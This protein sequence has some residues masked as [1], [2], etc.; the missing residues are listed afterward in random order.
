M[1]AQLSNSPSNQPENLAEILKSLKASSELS[2]EDSIS[3]PPEAFTS[4]ALLEL[5]REKIFSKEWICVGREGELQASGDYFVTE[6]NL[7]PVIMTRDHN[8]QL[9]ALVNVC[10]H[11][12]ARIADGAG[13]TRVFTCPYHSWAYDLDGRLVNAPKMEDKQF[14]KS[15]C[16][17]QQLRVET[18]LGF[19]F[20][21]LD[22]DAKPLAPRLSPLAKHF[23]NYHVERWVPTSKKVDIWK[24]NWKIAV[25]NFLEVYHIDSLHR[26]T[27]YMLGGAE[28]AKPGY[29]SDDYNFYIYAPHDSDNNGDDYDVAELVKPGTLVENPDLTDFERIHS[30]I[31]CIYPNFLVTVSSFGGA[32]MVPQPLSSGELRVEFAQF[33][34]I[35]GIEFNSKESEEYALA[36]MN[37]YATDFEDRPVV[38][39]IYSSAVS[40]YGKVGPLH[41]KHEETIYNFIRYLSKKLGDGQT[42]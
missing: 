27:L 10:R 4:E 18:W 14:D 37:I 31:G 13:K 29:H 24:S 11:R 36:K 15:K 42:N 23:E 20:V 1:S 16:S 3:M 26:D 32:Y 38:E 9:Q 5:E 25:E 21:N 6:V 19:I 40:G 33:G 22:P 28:S 8:N 39:G 7:V 17:L 12:M 35:E 30:P 41:V 2:L 34:P